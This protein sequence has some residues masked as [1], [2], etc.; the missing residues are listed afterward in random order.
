LR[1]FPSP[2]AALPSPLRLREDAA[3]VD[4]DIEHYLAELVAR[5]SDAL[6]DGLVG[7]WLCGSGALGDLDPATSDLDVQVVTTVRLPRAERERLAA[8]VSHPELPCPVRGLELVIYARDDL[9]DP[10]GPA[11]QVNLQHRSAHNAT[12]RL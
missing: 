3:M 11:F 10:L 8:R 12:R 2:L 7:A 5:L 6:G 4:A 1:L 9:E